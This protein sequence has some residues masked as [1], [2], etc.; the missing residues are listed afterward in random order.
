MPC[1][2]KKR[3]TCQRGRQV[4]W[5]GM[6]GGDEGACGRGGGGRARRGGGGV[7]GGELGLLWAASLRATALASDVQNVRPMA[8]SARWKEDRWVC[9][10]QGGWRGYAG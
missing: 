4:G 7:V 5:E 9:C 2:E 6:A 8:T 10:G 1:P 3:A